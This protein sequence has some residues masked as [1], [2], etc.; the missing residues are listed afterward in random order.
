MLNYFFLPLPEQHTT[1]TQTTAQRHNNNTSST[2]LRNLV[3]LVGLVNRVNWVNRASRAS[4][5]GQVGQ[6][7][8]VRAW[9]AMTL[10]TTNKSSKTTNT[11]NT[12]SL[13]SGNQSKPSSALS[14]RLVKVGHHTLI[15]LDDISMVQLYANNRV[16]MFH[17][18]MVAWPQGSFVWLN[19]SVGCNQTKLTF[20]TAAKAHEFLDQLANNQIQP[21]NWPDSVDVTCNILSF[22]A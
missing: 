12:S 1:P 10:T 21:D 11:T 15:N 17:K 9:Q 22:E 18:A 4:Q 5:F 13:H 16:V 20:K 8:Q 14:N 19:G 2:M 6:V 3:R 7:G